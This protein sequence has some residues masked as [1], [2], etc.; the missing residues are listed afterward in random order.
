[1][2]VVGIMYLIFEDFVLAEFTWTT[3]ST[4]KKPNHVT[5]MLVGVQ[6][7]LTILSILITRSTVLSMQSKNGVPPGN[8]AV[9][10]LV[11]GRA[12]LASTVLL[13]PRWIIC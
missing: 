5:R 7:G 12:R 6:V 10:W 4:P 13:R 8:Q 11:L 2:V 1:M 3:K 9:G